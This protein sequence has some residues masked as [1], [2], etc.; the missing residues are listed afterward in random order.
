[1]RG[2]IEDP[3]GHSQPHVDG[4]AIKR[5]GEKVIA[6]RGHRHAEVFAARIVRGEH[7]E[8]GVFRLGALADFLAKLE[9]IELGHHPV[10]DDKARGLAVELLPRDLPVLALKRP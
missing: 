5:F 1:M 4:L 9:A 7:D 2:E 6:A 10:A 3:R 8:V